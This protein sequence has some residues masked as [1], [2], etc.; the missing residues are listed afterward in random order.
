MNQITVSKS[1]LALTLKTNRDNHRAFYEEAVEVY[2]KEAARLAK[3]QAELMLRG[4]IKAV[5]VSIPVPE[6]HTEDYN[7]IIAMLEWSIGDTFELS[8]QDFSQYVND[9][10]GWKASFA[11]NTMSY[12]NR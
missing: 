2:R 12:T 7:R 1:N 8:E 11:A 6:D 9:D 3:E 5:R 10:W 4:E